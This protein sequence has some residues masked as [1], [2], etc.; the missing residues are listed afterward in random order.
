M[1]RVVT[2]EELIAAANRIK[3][4]DQRKK[5]IVGMCKRAGIKKYHYKE[6]KNGK[7]G[8]IIDQEDDPVDEQDVLE[9]CA[10][11]EEKRL[12]K[13][14]KITSISQQFKKL[15][16][17]DLMDYQGGNV[18]LPYSMMTYVKRYF[19]LIKNY[20]NRGGK[21]YASIPSVREDDTLYYFKVDDVL[22]K[23]LRK[24][25][26]KIQSGEVSF[27]RR[28]SFGRKRSK[29]VKKGSLKSLKQDLRKVKSC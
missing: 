6:G 1:I 22:G 28:T 9:E 23:D 3:N 2:K 18:S 27:G 16:K 17:E 13:I 15:S 7:Q 14:L 24:L 19:P 8:F 26:K 21:L 12:K 29:T 5:A 25:D 20:E 10:I 4:K 11:K